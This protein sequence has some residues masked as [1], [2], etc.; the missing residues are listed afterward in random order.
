[1]YWIL[2]WFENQEIPQVAMFPG[3]FVDLLI[4]SWCV[5]AASSKSCDRASLEMSTICE[6]LQVKKM[7]AY[8]QKCLQ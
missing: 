7:H 8:I 1:M 4:Y 2:F 3:P 6:N 5:A